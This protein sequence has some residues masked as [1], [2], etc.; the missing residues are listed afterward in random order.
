MKEN[1]TQKPKSKKIKVIIC[2]V[3]AVLIALSA[4]FTYCIV[5]AD[6]GKIYPNTYI[7]N[8]NVGN[9]TPADAKQLLENKLSNNHILAFYLKDNKFEIS[10]DEIS[11][12]I[13]IDKSIENVLN[14][15]KSNNLFKSGLNVLK[16]FIIPNKTYPFVT[17]DKDMLTMAFEQHLA[18]SIKDMVPASVT[19]GE[20]CLVLNNGA[21][22][23][24]VNT[25]KLYDMIKKDACDL[26]MNTPIEVSLDVLT[27]EPFDAD[28][29]YREYNRD[30]KDATYTETDGVYEF[31]KELNGIVL[32][33]D[34][35]VSIIKN[36]RNN[37]EDYIIPAVI[38]KAEVTVESLERKLIK[39][40][41]SA[42][43][44]SFASSDANRAHN[45]ML[46]SSKIDGVI[47]NPGDRFSYNKVVGPRT[48]TAG[49]KNAHVY[50]GNRIVDG[51]GGGIC[52]V[53][54]TLYNTVLMADL[55]IVKRTNHSMPVGYVPAGR[56][57]TV[58]YGTIDFVFENDKTYPVKI[59][60]TSANR[61]LTISIEGISDMDYTVDLYTETVSTR[62][63]TTRE[64]YNEALAPE[65][66]RVIQ[67]GTNGATVY[68]YK[69]Y[70]RDGVQFDKKLVGKSTYN[71]IEKIVETGVKPDVEDDNTED[72]A[73][74]VTAEEIT[75]ED[76]TIT[77]SNT[78][79]D[80]TE[81][82]EPDDTT[83][84]QN[85][86]TIVETNDA[87]FESVFEEAVVSNAEAESDKAIIENDGINAEN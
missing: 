61:T 62:P 85:T 43:T 28:K 9:M 37:K 41:I 22:G 40:V 87:E 66:T 82:P 33:Y 24:A 15:T 48:A 12:N 3:I 49:F 57:A 55:K 39:R 6:T 30:V 18:D 76:T 74:D 11:F 10:G 80:N 54:S 1:E 20:D 81:V 83:D 71:P 86:E 36:N 16:S 56:D 17:Y 79:T 14:A 34:E 46:A 29:L 47:L 5:K 13:D 45:V 72:I 52:Q 60:S 77:E 50:E 75:P 8:Y 78:V 19:E 27:P 26:F 35:V 7:G 59:C 67:S 32:N 21:T 44:T 73:Q 42:Y 25:K 68:T 70:K 84:T 63:F 64:V 65:Q 58:S 38:T 51:M 23:S 69:I 31:Q 4:I 2:C 53:S